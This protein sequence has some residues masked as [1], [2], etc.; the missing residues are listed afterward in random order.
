MFI[1]DE[2]RARRRQ[3]VRRSV[4]DLGE[5]RRMRKSLTHACVHTLHCMHQGDVKSSRQL[6]G[7]CPPAPPADPPSP[8]AAGA[9]PDPA[10]APPCPP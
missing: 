7:G 4:Q 6:A 10:P 5:H 2:R 3:L 8:P 9:P 1:E